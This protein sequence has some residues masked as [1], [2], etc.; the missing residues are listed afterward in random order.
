[1]KKVALLLCV[2]A[3]VGC[4][5]DLA[6][7]TGGGQDLT[8]LTLPL[9]AD[10]R[11]KLE[12]AGAVAQTPAEVAL[13]LAQPLTLVS[14]GC[15]PAG[16]P[17]SDR[18]VRVP[19]LM[20]GLTSYPEISLSGLTL[21]STRVA[22]LRA[23]LVQGVKDCRVT[24]GSDALEAYALAVDVERRTVTF[25]KAGSAVTFVAAPGRDVTRL[26]L[27]RDPQ[28]DWPLLP[29]QLTQGSA[30]LTGPFALTTDATRS[31]VSQQA[32]TQAGLRP[33]SEVIEAMHLPVELPIPA[34]LGALIL[35]TDSLEL[36]PALSLPHVELSLVPKWE[37]ESLVG[38]LG[39]DAWGRFDALIDLA[40]HALVLS[41][42]HLEGTLS[43]S[44]CG[45]PG[46]AS[47]EA[48]FQLRNDRVTDLDSTQR[49]R[50]VVTVWRAL[51]RGGRVEVEPLGADGKLLTVPC[52]FGFNFSPQPAGA[53][54]AQ[55]FP[56]PTLVQALPECAK[57]LEAARSFQFAIWSE[58][59]DRSCP[60][61][62][63]FAQD[64]ASG[65]TVCSCEQGPEADFEAIR[66]LLDH[67]QELLK[68]M[69]KPQQPEEP[70]PDAP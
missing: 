67:I 19:Q 21:G 47:G 2:A 62:C 43:G 32:A 11:L 8:G 25:Q 9:N 23:G 16:A 50:A 6:P 57:S 68:R 55:T 29:I 53:S 20:A 69:P 46:Q 40:G 59:Y 65:R 7:E 26:E 24:L 52:R 48:C 28:T 49:T 44:R 64:P 3:L 13:E 31:H 58:G 34:S 63:A 66:P 18:T 27:S 42:P 37:R 56:W 35:S 60:G 70:E 39:S 54:L 14:Q 10:G 17:A 45:A 30:R 61:S 5:P 12:V 38:T 22:P 15:F 4:H 41:R 36:S 1:M 33:A 51:P